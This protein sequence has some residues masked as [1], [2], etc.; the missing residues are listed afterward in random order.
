M[1]IFGD[2]GRAEPAAP[3]TMTPAAAGGPAAAESP[4]PGGGLDLSFMIGVGLRIGELVDEIRTERDRRDSMVP[5][6]NEQLFGTCVAD[7]DGNGLVDLGSCP[8][9]RAW[10]IRRL[11]VGGTSVTTAA[12]GSAYAFAQGAPP[13]DLA[14]TDC[15]DIFLTLPEGN[16]YGTHQFFL[17]PG[18]HLFVAFAGA[19]SGQQYV[20]SARVEDW[21]ETTFRSTFTE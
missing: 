4:G 14:L 15:A 12:A 7:A 9:G 2:T 19:T 20:A 3:V 11:I 13:R 8:Q 18:E 1:S 16:T 5:P 10:Q 17:L 6:S 21:E